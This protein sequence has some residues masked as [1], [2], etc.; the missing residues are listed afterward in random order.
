MAAATF[1]PL[2]TCSF[3][4]ELPIN[5]I[6]RSNPSLSTNRRRYESN[7]PRYPSVSKQFSRNSVAS[8]PETSVLRNL[9]QT[10][11]KSSTR[12]SSVV[13]SKSRISSS[14]RPTR[15]SLTY[16]LQYCATRS[17]FAALAPATSPS[18]PVLSFWLCRKSISWYSTNAMA[19][20][21]HSVE[22]CSYNSGSSRKSSN[23]PKNEP[24]TSANLHSTKTCTRAFFPSSRSSSTRSAKIIKTCSRTSMFG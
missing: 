6:A 10:T 7:R 15:S 18:T 16:S 1:R 9:D 14:V 3:E 19:S 17:T 5:S 12:S 2:L 8:D 21:K 24:R 20:P 11:I 22:Y 4:T 13:A 23:W